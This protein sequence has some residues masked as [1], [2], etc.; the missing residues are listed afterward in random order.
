MLQLAYA[1]IAQARPPKLRVIAE[2]A[3]A[4]RRV[5]IFQGRAADAAVYE[6]IKERAERRLAWF[7][8]QRT[9]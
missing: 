2:K 9:A 4:E 5:A 1:G 8:R 6:A 3:E 7:E